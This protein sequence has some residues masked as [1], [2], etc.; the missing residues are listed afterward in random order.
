MCCDGTWGR[1][2]ARGGGRPCPTNVTK[3]GLAV[4]ER[5]ADGREQ[6]MS[7]ENAAC[8]AVVRRSLRPGY[9]PPQLERYLGLPHQVAAVPGCP[10]EVA[11]PA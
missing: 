7:Q 10:E 8:S 1:P 11:A 5:D 2:D 9:A 3:L 6:R 4:A